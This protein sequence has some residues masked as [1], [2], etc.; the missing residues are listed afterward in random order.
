MIFALEN[1]RMI[2]KRDKIFELNARAKEMIK[3]HGR[4]KGLY[5]LMT[6]R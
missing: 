3:K 6:R 2:P 5:P 1:G 4:D